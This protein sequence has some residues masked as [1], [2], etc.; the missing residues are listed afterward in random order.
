MKA[1]PHVTAR[2]LTNNHNQTATNR[3]RLVILSLALAAVAALSHAAER[4]DWNPGDRPSAPPLLVTW[5]RP[6]EDVSHPGRLTVQ[7]S[8]PRAGTIRFNLNVVAF[9]LDFRTVRRSLGTFQLG[10]FGRMTHTISVR[11]LPIQSVSHSSELTVEAVIPRWSE[12]SSL[13]LPTPPAYYHFSADYSTVSV[14]GFDT[15]MD[16]VSGGRHAKNLFS[17]QGRAWNGKAFV[18]INALRRQEAKAAGIPVVPILGPSWAAPYAGGGIEDTPPPY[19]GFPVCVDWKT[20]FVDASAG[21]YATSSGDQFVDA[22]YAKAEI[23]KVYIDP[24]WF[25]GADECTELIWSGYLDSQ[26]CVLFEPTENQMYVA[27][28]YSELKKGN[29]TSKIEYFN[30]SQT[31]K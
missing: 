17:L 20:R 16:R 6:I 8:N 15:M 21:D 10:D 18:E 14:Y 27:N 25:G 23:R 19:V 28:V 12:K 2:G 5:D 26:G 11:D 29:I 22:A 9:G 31:N 3:T 4:D 24:C 7:V 1:Q 13:S 30:S